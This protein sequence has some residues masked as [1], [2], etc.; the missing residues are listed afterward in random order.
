MFAALTTISMT[1]FCTVNV[2]KTSLTKE[3]SAKMYEKFISFTT[4]V[5]VWF[6]NLRLRFCSRDVKDRDSN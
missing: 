2:S 6:D 1:K 5:N 3:T 4:K